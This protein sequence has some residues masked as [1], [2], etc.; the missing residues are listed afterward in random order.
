LKSRWL[1]SDSKDSSV[2]AF[3]RRR[4]SNNLGLALRN[5]EENDNGV[6]ISLQKICKESDI[7]EESHFSGS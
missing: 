6:I 7:L 5:K 1:K 4:E 2:I 3:P